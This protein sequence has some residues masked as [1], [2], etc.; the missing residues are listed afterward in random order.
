MSVKQEKLK[1]EQNEA[2]IFK[3]SLE[4]NGD[5]CERSTREIREALEAREPESRD[6]C[7]FNVNAFFMELKEICTGQ[8]QCEGCDIFNMC[9][10][11]IDTIK[12]EDVH[13][14]MNAVK[15]R[16]EQRQAG[17]KSI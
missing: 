17:N 12:M 13:R 2:M 7:D 5:Y 11:S 6:E 9:A 16:R 10:R 14:A 3:V 4:M 1:K 15:K 8:E